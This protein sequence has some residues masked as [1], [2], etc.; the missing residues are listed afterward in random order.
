MSDMGINLERS[1]LSQ[2]HLPRELGQELRVLRDKAIKDR[3]EQVELRKRIYND[4]DLI[5]TI[6][7]NK[8]QLYEAARKGE[9]QA[10][11]LLLDMCHGRETPEYQAQVHLQA[12]QIL[13]K[14]YQE[15]GLSVKVVESE[16]ALPEVQVAW[17]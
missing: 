2:R 12:A 9:S 8:N 5:A 14:M 15:E 3:E 17:A 11:I 7:Y 1:D 16:G 4:A 10:S 13:A 6:S